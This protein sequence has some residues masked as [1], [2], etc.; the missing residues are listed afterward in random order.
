MEIKTKQ[1][2]EVGFLT[3]T[4]SLKLFGQRP[5]N[6]MWGSLNA[7]TQL[8]NKH[9]S[10]GGAYKMDEGII[11]G[12]V[13][14]DSCIRPYT[15]KAALS[16]GHSLKQ[17]EYALFKARL[18]NLPYSQW[19]GNNVCTNGKTYKKISLLIKSQIEF[20]ELYNLIYLNKEKTITSDLLNKLTPSGLAIWYFDDGCY[21]NGAITISTNCF[22]YKEH[23]LIQQYFNSIGINADIRLSKQKYYQIYLNK[24]NT[25]LFLNYIYPYCS[26]FP[27]SIKYKLGPL[28][29]G[30]KENLI[31]MQQRKIFSSR[32]YNQNNKHKGIE[33]REKNKEMIAQ[34]KREYYLKNKQDILNKSKEYQIQNKELIS[35]KNRNYY[36]LNKKHII[37]NNKIWAEHNPEKVIRYKQ[38]YV[39][40]RL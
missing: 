9:L 31:L 8:N 26:D 14:G 39:D 18:L 40:K 24:K 33:Y 10:D 23:K 15:H 30:N 4:P 34:K 2:G 22:N 36:Q 21:S 12:M 20:L 29:E 27:D 5:K 3:Q 28:W 1:E 13:L 38:K 25:S 37:K 32:R 35:K 17:K 11:V 7:E 16:I 6:L 19:I